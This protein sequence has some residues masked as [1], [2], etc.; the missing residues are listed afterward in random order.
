[1]HKKEDFHQENI[2]GSS[3]DFVDIIDSVIRTGNKRER[4][5]VQDIVTLPALASFAATKSLGN[6]LQNQTEISFSF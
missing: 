3:A 4:E 2:S 1:M 6:V 5:K